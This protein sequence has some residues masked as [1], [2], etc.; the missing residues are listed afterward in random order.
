MKLLIIS[1]ILIGIVF[2]TIKTQN[3][4]VTAN[5]APALL[6][7]NNPLAVATFAGGCFWCVEA[8][9]EK[10]AGV[11]H[12]ISGFSGGQIKNPSYE[13][14]SR[15]TTE[16]LEAVQVFYNP[17]AITYAD[18]L[19]AFWRQINPTDREGQFV[20]RGKQYQSAIFYHSPEQ[21]EIADQSRKNLNDSNRFQQPIVTSIRAFNGFFPAEPYHQDYYLKNPLRYSFYRNNSGRDAYLEKTWGKD[22][23]VKFTPPEISPRFFKPPEKKIKDTLTP[24]QYRVTQ[25]DDTEEPFHNL[26]WDNKE[27]G[28][29]VD[30]VS[31]EP[32]FSSRDKYRSGTGWPSFTRP[33]LLNHLVTKK[34]NFLFMNRTEL[35]SFYGDS[36]LGHLFTDGPQP[37]GLRYCINSAALRF[38]PQQAMKQEGYGSLIHFTQP[39]QVSEI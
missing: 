21:K 36:H 32:L 35:R 12:V 9:F 20:D 26:Y 5:T 31:G 28:I 23:K 7:Q 29:Y 30:I 38:I 16:H 33:L 19:A 13:Q 8:D 34:D 25:E 2:Y 22:L 24:L 3:N 18:L 14:V 37:T 15:G 4:P 11:H 10:L 27:Q 17:A 1:L 6:T 39:T